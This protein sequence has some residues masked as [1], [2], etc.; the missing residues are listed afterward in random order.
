[1]GIDRFRE[2][3]QRVAAVGDIIITDASKGS[4]S[5]YMYDVVPPQHL[6]AKHLQY[7]N[8]SLEHVQKGNHMLPSVWN[9]IQR[10]TAE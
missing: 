7:I 5:I 8:S 10:W 4:F 2:A 1:M 6:L 3:D 9:N